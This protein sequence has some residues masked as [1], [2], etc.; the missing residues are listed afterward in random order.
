M[1]EPIKTEKY[2]GYTINI[3]Q[4]DDP[5]SPRGWDNFGT[6]VCFHRHYDLGDQH[7]M[8]VDELKELVRGKDVVALPLYLLDHSGLWM[9]THGFHDVDPQG[10]DWGQL[11]YIYAD[12]D[13]VRKELGVSRI[14]PAVRAKAKRILEDEVETYNKYL[15]GQVYGYVVEG[16]DGEH[17][18]SCWGFYDDPDAVFKEAKSVVKK[19]PYQMELPKPKAVR[20]S[21]S[22][23]S[24]TKGTPTAEIRGMRA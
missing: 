4:D 1:E 20:R 21:S 6:M 7:D 11:G 10:W 5:M 23:R 22:G 24:R 2:H 9:N 14:T 13:M 19:L 12:A 17:V 15:T 18:D 16:P 8:S 3:Y